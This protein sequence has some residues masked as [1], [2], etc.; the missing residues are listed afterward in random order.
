MLLFGCCVF[1]FVG[2]CIPGRRPIPFRKLTVMRMPKTCPGFPMAAPRN[3]YSMILQK[4]AQDSADIDLSRPSAN[5]T[6]APVLP[7]VPCRTA[8]ERLGRRCTEPFGDALFSTRPWRG[9]C[10][11]CQPV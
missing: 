5:L 10:A 8:V 1:C 4:L 9:I 6:L 7:C 3:R 2:V 11:E